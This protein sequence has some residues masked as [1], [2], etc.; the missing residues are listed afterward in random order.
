MPQEV[1][2]QKSLFTVHPDLI[3]GSGNPVFLLKTKIV[4]HGTA[5]S[6]IIV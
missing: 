3:S 4:Q 6:H 2:N 1:K 5:V